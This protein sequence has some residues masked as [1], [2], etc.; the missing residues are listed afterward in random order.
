MSGHTLEGMALDPDHVRPALARWDDFPVDDDP[1]RVVLTAPTPQWLDFMSARLR[2]SRTFDAP[3][4]PESEL[5]PEQ[6]ARA[7]SYCED[8]RSGEARPLGKIVRAAAR[9]TTDRGDQKLPAL[10]MFPADRR[11]PLAMV[12]TAFEQHMTWCPPG[13]QPTSGLVSW[14][15]E[16]D[17]TLTFRFQGQLAYV[18]DYP[19]AVVSETRTAVLIDPIEELLLGPDQCYPASSADREVV[20]R[21]AAPL[22]NRVLIGKGNGVGTSNFGSPL[23]VVPFAT[24]GKD[25][26]FTLWQNTRWSKTRSPSQ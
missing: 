12:D 24:V 4:V 3:A 19:A 7:L 13:L 25:D 9:F 26:G 1:R 5:T 10:V 16:D 6:L 17:Q 11:W 23:T 2:R 8:V 20:A 14:L 22:G 21:L 15:A 18:A